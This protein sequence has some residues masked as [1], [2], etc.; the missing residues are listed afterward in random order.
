MALFV[1]ITSFPINLLA[2]AN[3]LVNVFRFFFYFYVLAVVTRS[4]VT[5]IPTHHELSAPVANS[6]F[7]AIGKALV[8]MVTLAPR[9]QPSFFPRT[10]LY[11]VSPLLFYQFL[12]V[13]TM[14]V[15][16][17]RPVEGSRVLVLKHAYLVP[18]T[19]SYPNLRFVRFGI[20]DH[21]APFFRRF[22]VCKTPF[23]L[24]RN[25]RACHAR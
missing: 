10:R 17:E 3:R 1:A 19:V 7:T 25:D 15:V 22:P 4:T 13:V 16:G 18:R 9:Q 14:L 8:I 24:T 5:H 6:I 2:P 23:F 21:H 12:L 20:V 11:A